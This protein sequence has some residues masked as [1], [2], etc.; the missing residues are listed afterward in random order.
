MTNPTHPR[1]DLTGRTFEYTQA[2][3]DLSQDREHLNCTPGREYTILD[4]DDEF[5]GDDGRTYLTDAQA[6]LIPDLPPY[7]IGGANPEWSQ[8]T[9]DAIAAE[10]AASRDEREFNERVHLAREMMLASIGFVV[11]GQGTHVR[12]V[13]NEDAW[14]RAGQF[15]T[16]VDARRPK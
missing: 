8:E 4:E 3:A 14:E 13:T 2:M 10:L 5:D 12:S 16:F 11:D 9:G 15:L 1:R 6:N 7:E